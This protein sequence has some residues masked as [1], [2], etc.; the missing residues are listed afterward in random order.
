M[1]EEIRKKIID[2]Q[3]K[4]KDHLKAGFPVTTIANVFNKFKI[5]GRVANLAGCGHKRMIDQAN[6]VNSRQTAKLNF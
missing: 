3:V 5:Y 6:S 1:S 2:Q 4:G